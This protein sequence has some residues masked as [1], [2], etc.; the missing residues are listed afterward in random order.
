MDLRLRI[1]NFLFFL[2]L[3]DF[4]KALTDLEFVIQTVRLFHSFMKYGKKVFL[5][6]FVLDKRDLKTEVDTDL[7]K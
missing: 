4:F 6:D 1:L 2:H 7:N 5:K 3:I